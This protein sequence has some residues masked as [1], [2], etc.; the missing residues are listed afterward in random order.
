MAVFKAYGAPLDKSGVIYNGFNFSR[1]S[2]LPSTEEIR[3]KFNITTKFVV[4]MVATFSAYKDYKTYIKGALEVLKTRDDVSFLCIGDGDDSAFRA[5]VPAEKSNRILFLGKQN[6]VESIMNICDI[7]VLATDVRNHAEGISNA[8]MEFMALGKP[9]IATNFGGSVELVVNGKTGYL[10]EAYDHNELATR[11]NTLLSSDLLRT[12]M[13]KASRE[14][15]E[16]QFSID[17]MVSSF[18]EEYQSLT[19]ELV[20]A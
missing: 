14:R 2:Q 16:T 12:E 5:L 4:A 20:T 3:T 7:G 19:S 6:K 8:L 9:V 11:V 15:V 13:G 18:Y 17:K 10:V 1:L